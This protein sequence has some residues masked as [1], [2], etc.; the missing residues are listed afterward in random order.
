MGFFEGLFKVFVNQVARTTAR[1]M[2]NNVMSKNWECPS[3]GN[4]KTARAQ[5]F[6]VDGEYICTKCNNKR[7]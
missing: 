7:R 4:M 5:K 1:N 3:C 2:T 6:Y